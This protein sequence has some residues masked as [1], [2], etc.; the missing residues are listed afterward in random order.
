MYIPSSKMIKARYGLWLSIFFTLVSKF[1]RADAGMTSTY[2]FG[3][4]CSSQGIWTAD[5]LSA[6]KQIRIAAEQLKDDKNCGVLSNKLSKYLAELDGS[7]GSIS[8]STRLAEQ[9]RESKQLILSY[10]YFM[11]G[12]VNKVNSLRN[13]PN[14]DQAA[15][16][17]LAEELVHFGSLSAGGEGASRLI[18]EASRGSNRGNSESITAQTLDNVNVAANRGMDLVANVADSFLE[19]RQCL[20]ASPA[21]FSSY[22]SSLIALSGAVIGSEYDSWGT[23]G[24]SIFSKISR[25]L[26]DANFANVTKQLMRTDFRNSTSCLMEH[27]SEKYCTIQD[28]MHIYKEQMRSYKIV[29]DQSHFKRLERAYS[30]S[31]I[32]KSPLQ[33][34]YIL[35]QQVPIITSWL[36]KI[37]RGVEPQLK[38]DA[39]FKNDVITTTMHFY[40]GEN[41][42]LSMVNSDRKTLQSFP[43]LKAKRNQVYKTVFHLYEKLISTGGDSVTGAVNFYTMS[44]LSMEIPFYLLGLPVPDEVKGKGK[45]EFMQDSFQYLQANIDKIKEFEHPETLFESVSTNLRKLVDHAQQSA[46]AFYNE[47]FIFD[48]TALYVDAMTGMRYNVYESLKNVDTY[49]GSLSKR[50]SEQ[51]SKQSHGESIITAIEDT[52][53]R[54]GAILNVFKKI[55]ET[56]AEFKNIQGDKVKKEENIK[57]GAALASELVQT[58]Y[59][60]FMVLIARSNFLVNRI[61]DFVKYDF[62]NL[63]RTNPTFSDEVVKEFFFASGD[64]AFEVLKKMSNENPKNV[65]LDLANAE[66]TMK[67]NLSSM[68]LLLRDNFAAMIA[69]MKLI[70]ENKMPNDDVIEKDSELRSWS[71]YWK[72]Y[73]MSNL[74]VIAG[75]E[76]SLAWL[77]SSLGVGFFSN[78]DRYPR[79]LSTGFGKNSEMSMPLDSTFGTARRLYDLYC[80][81]ALAFY[82]QRPFKDLCKNS[83][84]VHDFNVEEL[85]PQDQAALA[86]ELNI[87]Y[88]KLLDADK[89]GTISPAEAYSKRICALRDYGRKTYVMYLTLGAR[90]K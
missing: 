63:L 38:T 34:Y 72:F 48:N 86:N 43:D 54:L 15:M 40:T 81:Q 12:M 19:E 87:E 59:D 7:L 8:G 52:R 88:K 44:M 73:P 1:A 18:S 49:L 77:K 70:A 68:E 62:Q 79:M 29:E 11:S 6:T 25:L 22:M 5:A 74:G 14:L 39:I 69:Y 56:S 42:L 24:G 50:L 28:S 76:K 23:K 26:R 78:T 3:P 4:G 61:S 36:E 27:I 10:R 89:N 67:E 13:S 47:W 21:L 66:V 55:K 9:L 82:D 30:Y 83:K 51:D 53:K 58:V 2:T 16:N 75:F 41:E 71:D 31:G 45:S 64:A 84:L 35:T 17:G 85:K 37:Q 32:R 80:T 20:A 60:N 90:A 65:A 46:I 57:K 33:G